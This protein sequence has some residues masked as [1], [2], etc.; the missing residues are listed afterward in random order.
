MMKSEV[1]RYKEILETRQVE[2][3]EG[4]RNRDGITIEKSPDALDEFQN[5][6]N[7]GLKFPK[8]AD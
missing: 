5:A 2:L 8:S 6:V 7:A 3:V 4:L 1:N